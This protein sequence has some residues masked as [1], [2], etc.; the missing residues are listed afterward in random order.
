MDE[1]TEG[2]W[3]DEWMNGWM[4]DDDPS[5]SSQSLIHLTEHCTL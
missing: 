3:M 5:S 1:K 4:D 2:E